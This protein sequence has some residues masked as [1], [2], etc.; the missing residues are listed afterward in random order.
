MLTRTSP[1]VGLHLFE[2]GRRCEFCRI[3]RGRGEVGGL[4]DHLD[5]E[6]RGLVLSRWLGGWRRFLLLFP[7][8]QPETATESAAQGRPYGRLLLRLLLLGLLAW[9]RRLPL[10]AF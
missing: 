4:H 8:A 7:F 1:V 10:H 3:Y 2:T 5:P 9:G 6:S